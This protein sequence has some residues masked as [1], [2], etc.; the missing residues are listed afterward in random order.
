MPLLLKLVFLV[1]GFLHPLC[2]L[3]PGL[4]EELPLGL[5]DV[6]QQ[7]SSN[8]PGDGG[9][10]ELEAGSEGVPASLEVPNFSS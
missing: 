1:P 9:L 4:V 10:D 5:T 6:V 2:L 3:H 8:D 7:A